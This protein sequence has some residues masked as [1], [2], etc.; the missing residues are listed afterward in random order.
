MEVSSYL[1]YNLSYWFFK[2]FQKIS[3]IC[4][5]H[6]GFLSNNIDA[7]SVP[8]YSPT[9]FRKSH[10]S[11]SDSS[12]RF[13]NGSQKIGLESN[14]TRPLA[15]EG[16]RFIYYHRL[17]QTYDNTDWGF[18][19]ELG[20]KANICGFHW[21]IRLHLDG[22]NHGSHTIIRRQRYRLQTNSDLVFDLINPCLFCNEWGS[23]TKLPKQG[24]CQNSGFK[25]TLQFSQFLIILI[26][27]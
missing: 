19:G 23:R 10:K 21:V 4:S 16:L 3:A 7:I 18:V 9:I 5:R 14:F 25:M 8:F 20:S 6:L 24:V 2:V 13:G 1:A 12:M 26:N 15:V 17:L 22:N 27:L 11:I